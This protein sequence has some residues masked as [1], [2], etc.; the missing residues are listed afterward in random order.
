MR[1]LLIDDHPLI[2]LAMR[3]LLSDFEPAVSLTPAADAATAHRLLA[4][5]PVFDLVL[6]SLQ[7][8]DEDG[9]ALLETLRQGHP[10]LPIAVMS[11]GNSMAEVIRAIDQG[12]M[13]FIPKTSD[14][15]QMKEALELVVAGGI[16]IPAMRMGGESPPPPPGVQSPTAL[17]AVAPPPAPRDLESLPITARQHEVLRG[18]LMGKP[19]KVI[20]S[21]LKIS[22]DTVKDHVQA[23]FRA[24]GVNS[25]T[26]AVLAVSQMGR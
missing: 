9:F 14:P 8:G 18:L 22:A 12:A 2:H 5:E 7:L 13:A 10:A 15:A 21:E 23:I 1:L 3:A 16:Y 24:L 25:R 11:A 4:S 17:P 20:A 6:L 19:N 26:Q